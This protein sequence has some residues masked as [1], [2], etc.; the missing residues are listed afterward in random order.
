[1][2]GRDN[3]AKRLVARK[4]NSQRGP[5][6]GNVA[7][8]MIRKPSTPMPQRIALI[9]KTFVKDGNLFISRMNYNLSH[10]PDE[11]LED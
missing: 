11:F 6:V 5:S 2:S 4:K 3:P 10:F 1:M 9:N 7:K 8:M